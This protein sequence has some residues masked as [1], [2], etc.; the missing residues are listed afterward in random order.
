[1]FWGLD[2]GLTELG[3]FWG[4]RTPASPHTISD[5]SNNKLKK[6]AITYSKFFKDIINVLKR[7]CVNLIIG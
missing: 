3:I 4:A 7:K 2:A 5:A 1:M 6:R